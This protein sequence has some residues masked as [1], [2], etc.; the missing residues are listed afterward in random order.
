MENTGKLWGG[1]GIGYPIPWG[2]GEGLES[3]AVDKVQG[4]IPHNTVCFSPLLSRV[5][6]FFSGK[7]GRCLWLAGVSPA[8]GAQWDIES[9]G[10][11]GSS[12]P[13]PGRELGA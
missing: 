1:W 10:R 3:Q 12:D 5:S 7:G 2:W 13:C 6:F 9:R 8:R 11:A 4:G